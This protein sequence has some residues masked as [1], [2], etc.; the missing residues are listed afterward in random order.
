MTKKRFILFFVF[1]TLVL[2]FSIL[3][4]SE[5]PVIGISGFCMALL[6]YLAIDLYNTRHPAFM[7]V[8]IILVINILIG[9]HESI[10]FIGHFFGAIA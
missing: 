2:V 4:L 7:Q 9:L 1:S 8:C 6:S 5:S 10:S 3:F